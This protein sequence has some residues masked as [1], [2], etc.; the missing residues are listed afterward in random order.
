VELSDEVVDYS[1]DLLMRY[2]NERMP[3]L[4]ENGEYVPPIRRK[5]TVKANS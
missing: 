2:V 5:S 3:D 4:T 1:A